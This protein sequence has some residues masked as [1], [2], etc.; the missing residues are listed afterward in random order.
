[1]RK[2]YFLYSTFEDFPNDRVDLTE[3]FSAGIACRGHSIDW[4][5]HPSEV[6]DGRVA[7]IGASERVF[8]CTKKPSTSVQA[9]LAN[10]LS[11]LWHTLSL[12]GL[13]KQNPYDFVQVRDQVFGAL[14]ALIGCI[15]ACRPFVFWM[16]FP[17]VEADLFKARDTSLGIRSFKR[18]LLF[19]RGYLSSLT[20][21]RIILP[22]AAYVFVQSDKMKEDLIRKGI[23]RKK[24]TPVPMGINWQKISQSAGLTADEDRFPEQPVILYMGTLV[25]ARRLDFLIDVV[26]L[27]R[28]KFPKVTLALVG[29]APVEDLRLIEDAVRA[30]GLDEHVYLTGRVPMEKAWHMVSLANVCLS[31][32][33]PSPMLDSASPTKV[34]EYLALGRPVVANDQPD[35]SKVIRESGAGVVVPYDVRK[36][37]DA[38]I[39]LLESPEGAEAMGQKGPDYVRR[40]RSYESMIPI[41][42]AKYLEL[43]GG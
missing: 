14:I 1:M 42:E 8:L 30:R 32:F 24:I 41:L 17:Y 26:D 23:D 2:L 5:M 39:D 35:Q 40:H 29:D 38:V 10:L 11:R 25:R 15:L 34:V 37:A 22:S 6:C 3:L 9:R 31:P 28:V 36:F 33:R 18:W 12:I 13:I 19:I 7:Q 16:S 4:H 21:Y 27:V 43:F 20:L